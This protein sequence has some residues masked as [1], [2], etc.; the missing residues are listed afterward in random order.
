ME[1][2]KNTLLD[3]ELD[4]LFG[5][6]LA[7]KVFPGA[8]VA[9]SFS[10]SYGKTFR[11]CREYG[12][13][14]PWKKTTSVDGTTAWDLASLT[15]PLVTVLT[16]LKLLSAGRLRWHDS[17]GDLLPDLA[18]EKDKR[19]IR[20]D[21][22]MSHCS[23]LVAHRPYYVAMIGMEPAQR[24]RAIVERILAEPLH[25][26]PG[27]TYLYSDLGYILLAVV[28]ERIFGC[29]L[30]DAYISE[31]TKPLGLSNDLF[32][33]P[34]NKN[35]SF[36]ATEISP[37]AN[38]LL[39]GEVHDDNCRICGNISGHAGLFGTVSGVLSCCE[40]LLR[41]YHNEVREPLFSSDILRLAAARR[42]GTAWAC[43]FDTPAAVGSSSGRHFSQESIGHLGFT[44]TS[45]WID[46][47]KSVVVVLLTNR[48]CPTR[49]D[50]R[51]KRFRPRLHNVVME[52][53]KKNGN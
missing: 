26:V 28:I 11:Y 46:L 1:F 53:L 2:G 27:T 44:G 14:E 31:I 8:A 3:D 42:K 16:L 33:L 36:A 17:L 15:K 34:G 21:E 49:K 7:E 25:S 23:G 41:V 50:E 12:Y 37:W 35:V 29:S 6:A 38:K 20:L 32:F 45:F 30:Q 47:R 51:I 4:T 13:T 10:D 18:M 9:V 39:C 24:R 48:V 22:L 5:E 43:G 40:Y 52:C 19:Q